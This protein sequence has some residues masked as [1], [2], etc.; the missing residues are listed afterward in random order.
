MHNPEEDDQYECPYCGGEV[1]Y[2]DP[3]GRL[4]DTLM[5]GWCGTK[6]DWR[7]GKIISDHRDYQY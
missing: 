4:P 1:T 7:T 2:W 3:D 5:C 6:F